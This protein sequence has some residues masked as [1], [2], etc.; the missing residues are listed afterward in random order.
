MQ[1]W[2]L[3]LGPLALS[4]CGAGHLD[5]GHPDGG[6][7]PDPTVSPGTVTLHLTLPSAPSFCDVVAGCGSRTSYVSFRTVAGDE[8]DAGPRYCGTQC[9]TCAALPCPAIPIC[10][11]PAVG[12]SIT[13]VETT[14]DGSFV[15]SGSCG[16]GITCFSPRFVQPGRYVAHMCATP[17]TLSMSAAGGCLQTGDTQCMDVPFDIPGPSPVTATLPS[18]PPPP[19]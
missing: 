14:W 16:D 12:A 4:A 18:S 5:G 6:S 11:A 1:R 9:S 15:A 10:T 17:G 19:I 7:P 2:F 13:Y 3:F 8:L